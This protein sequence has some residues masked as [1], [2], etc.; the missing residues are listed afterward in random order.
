MQECGGFRLPSD[1]DI[2]GT[3][4]RFTGQCPMFGML[5]AGTQQTLNVGCRPLM[6]K[7]T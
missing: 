1:L 3:R 4:P 6:M 2:R 5:R 7:L